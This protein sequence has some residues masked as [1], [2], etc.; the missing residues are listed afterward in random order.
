MPTL[1]DL[2]AAP[3][4]NSLV[5]PFALPST[6]SSVEAVVLVETT[7]DLE[8]AAARSLAV[9]TS[10]ASAEAASYRLDVT[11]RLAAARGITG[12]VLCGDAPGELSATAAQVAERGGVAVLWARAGTNLSQL[13]AS[14]QR[15]VEGDARA[16]LAR[17]YAALT[18]AADAEASSTDAEGIVAAAAEALGTPLALR[19]P[20]PGERH[21]PVVV[22]GNVEASVCAASEAGPASA[23]DLVLNVTASV[24][25][26][27]V[28]AQRH[29]EELPARS[30]AELLGELLI[31]DARSD[32]A[33]ARRA[34]AAGIPVD[35]WHTAVL[36]EV[37]NL[38]E[39]A[40]DE[41]RAF[42]L[43]QFIGRVALESAR[44]AGETWHRTRLGS[45]LVL[46]RTSRENPGSL[47]ASEAADTASRVLRRLTTRVP[48]LLM[49]CGVGG[50]HAG[51]GGLRA[52]A[53]EARAAIAAARLADR[54][55]SPVRF[56]AVGLR[57]TLIEWY[58]S[59]SAREAVQSVLAPLDRLGDR[60]AA[61]AI[62]TLEAYLD[63]QGSLARTAQTLHLHRNAVSYRI[64]RVFAL[65]D[66]DPEDADQRLLLH[67]ACRAR[68]L[69]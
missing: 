67:L 43:S 44:A 56:D 55:N 10:R 2:L 63:N 32:G 16:A 64:K 65:L 25:A 58:G 33:L 1:A 51:A 11:L 47:G 36:L 22:D 60:K 21:V 54:S 41:V 66:V 29:A 28:A 38:V 37:R 3:S 6:A 18:A 19:E 49:L 7:D 53:A 50:V 13:L 24:V 4:V 52:S 15:E 31:A 68:A 42:E 30:S 9:L 27:A 45:A 61:T 12:L 59:D 57:R 39:L 26:R 14:L 35:G 48:G 40:G 34:R 8:S 20:L 46:V 17:A 23:V 5:E 62:R 69:S